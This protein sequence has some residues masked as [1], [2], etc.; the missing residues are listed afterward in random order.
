MTKN[1]QIK[2][3]DFGV[4]RIVIDKTK[5]NCGTKEY[6]SP[7]M[8]NSLGHTFS[9]DIWSAGCVLYE[10]ITLKRYNNNNELNFDNLKTKNIFKLLLKRMLQINPNN[11][12]TAEEL[13]QII[14]GYNKLE[15]IEKSLIGYKYLSL[16]LALFLIIIILSYIQ[17][18][19]TKFIDL[20]L[21]NLAKLCNCNHS[22]S[23]FIELS[24]KSI[25]T[26]DSLTFNG[27]NSLEGLSLG[28]NKLTTIDRAIFKNLTSLQTLWLYNNE[29]ESIDSLAFYDLA[30][31]KFLSLQYNKIETIHPITLHSLH[32]LRNIYLSSNQIKE[33]HPDTFN[34]LKNLLRLGLFG[35]Q[36]KNIHSNT[37]RDLISLK[38]LSL[39]NNEL[40]T[41]D[42]TTFN[43]MCSLQ[44]LFLNYN[45][46][47]RVDS[48]AFK[49]LI[50][51]QYLYLDW[52]Q[53]ETIESNTFN[54]LKSLREIRLDN[55][56]IKEIESSVF[57][58]MNSLVILNLEYN[59]I[60]SFNNRNVLISNLKNL[61][62]ICLFENPIANLFPSRFLLD[63]QNKCMVY[64]ATRC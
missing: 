46:I 28:N 56:Q 20:N 45:K 9:T 27:L 33:I 21:N 13:K 60:V 26:I 2:I 41:I 48:N 14:S 47:I 7:E 8:I 54:D 42:S 58:E 17:M 64:I 63:I 50:S 38:Y 22:Q 11:R 12:A 10:L 32:S 15:D 3:G 25:Q 43:S 44:Q 19:S 57:I 4:A 24:K 59:N 55:N 16:I 49:G 52:N 62:K 37:F 51:L 36:I 39:R 23:Y 31:L 18:K 6:M 61:E 5:T 30:C 53:I 29:I 1:N 34:G 40:K 35:N